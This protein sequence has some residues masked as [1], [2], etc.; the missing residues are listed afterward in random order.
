M[1]D[2]ADAQIAAALLSY[3]LGKIRSDRLHPWQ[4]LFILVGLVTVITA[5]I[6]YFFLDSRIEDAKFLNEEEREMAIER[7]RANQTGNVGNRE[8]KWSHIWELAYD[9]KTYLFVSRPY[10][11]VLPLPAD[12]ANSECH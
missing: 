7:V 6:V 9:P 11:W 3:G 10:F 4:S 8:F 2:I 12:L 1:E 5:P